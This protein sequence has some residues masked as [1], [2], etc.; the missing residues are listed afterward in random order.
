M[1]SPEVNTNKID[2]SYRPAPRW[3]A[4]REAAGI[5]P[6]DETVN[7]SPSDAIVYRQLSGEKTVTMEMLAKAIRPD[8]EFG[9]ARRDLNQSL[10]RL[11]KD[12]P[13]LINK[14]VVNVGTP[15]H[16]EYLLVEVGKEQ[17]A[18]ERYATERERGATEESAGLTSEDV[19]KVRNELAKKGT[20]GRTPKLTTIKTGG[21]IDRGRPRKEQMALSI[22]PPEIILEEGVEV[23]IIALDATSIPL[24][25]SDSAR[26][27]NKRMSPEEIRATWQ[28]IA[29][30]ASEMFLS[31]MAI[32]GI[33]KEELGLEK[34]F[35]VII[36]ASIPEERLAMFRKSTEISLPDFINAIRRTVEEAWAQTITPMQA[37]H[38]YMDKKYIKIL[39]HRDTLIKQHASIE[40]VLKSLYEHFGLDI[41]AEYETAVSPYEQ[42]ILKFRY[43]HPSH[44]RLKL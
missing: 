21:T 13:S 4:A 32:L 38:A 31:R 39:G 16:A 6:N 42:T 9:K 14:S 25:I 36:R 15:K 22:S 17:E 41:P 1:A 18:I 12:L 44:G 34:N 30:E 19:N 20:T 35:E 5:N 24:P 3:D 37:G 40:F 7:M 11:R 33:L 28:R 23:D 2:W 8:A 26:I 43:G 29:W 10:I 27:R